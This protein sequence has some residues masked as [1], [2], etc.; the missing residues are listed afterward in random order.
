MSG[1][2]IQDTLAQMAS[3]RAPGTEGFQPLFYKAFRSIIKDD[4]IAA[5]K[6]FF[7]SYQMAMDWKATYVVLIPKKNNPREVK[8]YQPISLW[9]I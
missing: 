8:D 6:E 1:W 5:I 3:N 9:G 7:S 2:E 4:I